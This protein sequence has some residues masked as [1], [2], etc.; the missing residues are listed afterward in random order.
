MLV[1][2]ASASR[3]TA[4][5]FFFFLLLASAVLVAAADT[6]TLEQAAAAP[7]ADLPAGLRDAVA[8][9]VLRVKGPA[10]VLCEI[11]LRKAVPVVAAPS[12]ELGVTFGQIAD[13][14][15]LGVMR[16]AAA[17][18]DYR[19]QKVKP[20]L[21]T[22]RYALQPVDGNH[23]GTAPQRDFALLSPVA[24]D[25]DPATISHDEALK[26]SAKT[27]G[28]KHPSV[29]SLWPAEDAAAP[30]LHFQSDLQIWMLSFP[31]SLGGGA[32]VSMGMV[33][34]GHAPEA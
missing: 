5:F 6:Y 9:D 14:T 11:W 31:L 7:P 25:S 18:T 20:G 30:S 26:R 34:V 4:P 8:P 1:P 17:T 19:E 22:L 33:V 29:W 21:Y 32:R 3:G 10:G 28:T 2:S 15:F 23:T 24:D 12:T 27:T 16:V 13:G